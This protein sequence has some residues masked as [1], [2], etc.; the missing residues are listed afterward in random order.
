M[1]LGLTLRKCFSVRSSGHVA[2]A[3][4]VGTARFF[5]ASVTPE[6]GGRGAEFDVC[7]S[8]KEMFTDRAWTSPRTS[9]RSGEI[10]DA[11]SSAA[12]CKL[13]SPI[14]S[15]GIVTQIIAGTSQKGVRRVGVRQSIERPCCK[16]QVWNGKKRTCMLSQTDDCI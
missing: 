1:V 9:G 7:H 16:L 2:N 10:G 15:A 4:P 12:D 13:S 11:V 3:C 8:A 5:L 14:M 6:N